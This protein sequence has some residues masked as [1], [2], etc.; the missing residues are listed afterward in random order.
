MKNIVLKEDTDINYLTGMIA[1]LP[2]EEPPG[3]VMQAVMQ[4]ITPKPV[5][6][7]RRLWRLLMTPFTLVTIRP[8]Y[9]AGT[10]LLVIGLLFVFKTVWMSGNS[11]QHTA[12]LK[13]PNSRMV[14]FILDY[15]SAKKAA[16]IGSFNHWQP[17]Q[18]Q[19]HR[20][21]ADGTWQITVEL[22][23][24]R[25]SYAFVIDNAKIIADPRS[26]WEQDD[27]FGTR[28]SIL[29]IDNGYPDGKRI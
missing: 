21:P 29:T 3:D 1:S 18:Y 20:N 15:P 22:Q 14:N 4:R 6:L 25:H 2:D 16:V 17:E 11:F 23:P 9:A 28:N 7:R 13:N 19:M 24:G 12:S 26:L 8:L 27:G 5:S 10:M